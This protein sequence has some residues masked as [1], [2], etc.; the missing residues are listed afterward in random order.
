[1]TKVAE[2]NKKVD[3]HKLCTEALKHHISVAP[4][5]IFSASSNYANYVRISYGKP[6]SEEIEYGVMMLGKLIKKMVR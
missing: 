2:L 4:G 6:W 5:Q 1:M 3:A